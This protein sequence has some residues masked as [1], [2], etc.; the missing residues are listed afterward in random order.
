[1]KVCLSLVSSV[2]H[3]NELTPFSAMKVGQ[4]YGVASV[5]GASVGPGFIPF[6][7]KP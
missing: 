1:M 3:S 2:D 5:F 7:K 4:C 6:W